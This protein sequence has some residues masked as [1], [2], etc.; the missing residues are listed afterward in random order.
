MNVIE[1]ENIWKEYYRSNSMIKE[2]FFA[3]LWDT[4]NRK[5]YFWALRDI[6][7]TIK[8]GDV[9]GIIGKNGSGKSTLLKLLSRI[10]V[11]TRGTIRMRG[12]VGSLLEVGT[13]FHP[14][15]TG[16]ENIFLNGVILGMSRDH[17][18]NHFDAI[19]SFAGVHDFLDTPVKK[20]SSGMV[21]RLA[22]SV[23][24]H[25]EP[26]IL[27]ID[28][29]LA[30]GDSEFQEKC[31]RV[32]NKLG[33]Q[34]R[35]VVF[36]SHDIAA[37]R[38][39]C[40]KALL[41][42]EGRLIAQG[43]VDEV[44]EHYI[45]SGK[46]NKAHAYWSESQA[47]QD[48]VIS[49]L[50]VKAQDRQGSVQE[51]FNIHQDMYIKLVYRVKKNGYKISPILNFYD[52]QGVHLFL[53]MDTLGTQWQSREREPGVYTS[54][55]HIPKDFFNNGHIWVTVTMSFSGG[56]IRFVHDNVIA[57]DVVDDMTSHGARADYIYRW[58]RCSVRPIFS[59]HT[60]MDK[61]RS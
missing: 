14:E 17:V 44:V 7:Y 27:I 58:P 47:P 18:K 29:I 41:L 55:C 12:S 15:L 31:L 3:T 11:A 37:V 42:S 2:S 54:V 25:L 60:H 20:Y 8:Q 46:K 23:A 51:C 24:A 1:I 21:L 32:M 4:P 9:V 30:V 13:G 39:L 19:V 43:N 40:N 35:T 34:G 26:E 56:S 52:A 49:L 33:N 16:R 59:W 36:V 53:T 45:T 57:F 10:T 5:N 48:D 28:E 22:F 38:R 6:S 61:D 50:E